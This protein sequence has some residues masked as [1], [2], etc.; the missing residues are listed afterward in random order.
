MGVGEVQV[1][2]VV[3]YSFLDRWRTLIRSPKG[4]GLGNPT[5]DLQIVVIVIVI[6]V[7][8]G[9]MYTCQSHTK[10]Q[11]APPKRHSIQAT[12]GAR[13]GAWWTDLVGCKQPNMSPASMLKVTSD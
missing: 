12:M 3:E 10:H 5:N 4:R 7:V 2:W 8:V 13:V 6:V 11:K 9:C 1:Y